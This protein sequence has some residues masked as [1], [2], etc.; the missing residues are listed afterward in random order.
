M[1]W[2]IRLLRWSWFDPPPWLAW[3]VRWL[4]FGYTLWRDQILLLFCFLPL[5]EIYLMVLV[6]GFAGGWTV[7][8]SVFATAML[9][10]WC[11][12]LQGEDIL[13]RALQARH[14]DRVPAEEIIE[15]IALL[16]ACALLVTPGYVTDA[17]G[18]ILLVPNLRLR[19]IDLIFSHVWGEEVFDM[20]LHA[21][22]RPS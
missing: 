10:A 7:L 19:V 12:G 14:A 17:F 9:G 20:L 1:R 18:F 16:V 13:S 22:R 3:L 5:L 11:F 4:L 6:Y 8:V 15:G 21:Y 2:L